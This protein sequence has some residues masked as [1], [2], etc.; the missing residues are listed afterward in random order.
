ME[1]TAEAFT[2]RLEELASAE[3]LAKI[4]RYFK[5]GDGE[6]GAG[7]VFLGVRMGSVFALAK[8]YAAMP[9]EEIGKLLD[10]PVHEVRAGALSVMDKQARAAKTTVERR[11]ELYELYLRRMD[12]IDNWDLVDLG[13]PYV[14]GGW[15]ADKPRDVLYAM[16][17]SENLWE[18][19]TAML[20]TLCFARQ[21]D[22]DDVYGIAEVLLSD[23][24]D[25]IRKA[26]GGML[27][28]AGKRDR[29]TLLTFLDAHAARMPRTMLRYAIE[30]LDDAQRAHYRSL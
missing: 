30:H 25:L 12:R 5:T 13:A 15:L 27:R 18:R 7:D 2:A 20:A 17:R 22:L 14:V 28:E 29:P 21:N 23:E 3:E 16:A 26:V 19:R 8:E 6:Y 1:L 11:A 10:S 9:P 24:H 4:Q